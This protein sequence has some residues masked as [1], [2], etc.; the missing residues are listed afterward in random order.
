MCIVGVEGWEYEATPPPPPPPPV[1]IAH[2][3]GRV[4][5][6]LADVQDPYTSRY[7]VPQITSSA[8]CHLNLVVRVVHPVVVPCENLIG[9]REHF[10]YR[11]F[12]NSIM[13]VYLVKLCV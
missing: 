11:H 5:I 3:S 12:K 10:I 9:D 7:V 2:T 8:V 4:R 1:I 6:F 13:E